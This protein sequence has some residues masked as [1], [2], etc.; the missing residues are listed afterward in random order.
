MRLTRAEDPLEGLDVGN[1]VA[2]DLNLWQSLVPGMGRL[3][4]EDLES[5][6]DLTTNGC[7]KSLFVGC[8]GR[9]RASL[10]GG[11]GFESGPLVAVHFF[12]YFSHSALI[13]AQ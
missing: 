9:A 2:Q 13:Y 6:V 1:G 7:P 12:F 5:L 4:P 8:G 11:F 3:L 10:L